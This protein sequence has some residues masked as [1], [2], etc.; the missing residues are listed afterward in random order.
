MF[1]NKLQFQ[2]DDDKKIYRCAFCGED[3][4][5]GQKYCDIHKTQAGR[6]KTFEENVAIIKQNAK[7]G[8]TVPTTMPSWK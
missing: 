2:Y 1:D 6:K 3:A 7:L 4:K 8:Y 5:K